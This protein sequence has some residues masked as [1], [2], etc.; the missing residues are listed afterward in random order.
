MNS[1]P[2]NI[3]LIGLGLIGSSLARVIKK[4]HLAKALF[5]YAKSPEHAS[6]ALEIGIIDKIATSSAQIAATCDIVIICTPLTTYDGIFQEIAPAI[7]GRDCIISDVGSLKL[8]AISMANKYFSQ[9]NL[10]NFVP[11]HPIAGTEKTGVEAGFAEL[12][13]HKKLILTPTEETSQ[14]ALAIVS[15]FWCDCGSEVIKLAAREHD[16]IYAEVSHLP[17]FLAYCY[18]F[19]LAEN[20]KLAGHGKDFYLNT[21]NANQKFVQFSRICTSD[22]IIWYGIFAMNMDYLAASLDNFN[23]ELIENINKVKAGLLYID[24]DINGNILHALIEELP[25]IISDTLIKCSPNAPIYAGSGFR[26]LTSFHGDIFSK[27]EVLDSLAEE[28][29]S[30]A[31]ALLQMIKAGEYNKSMAFMQKAAEWNKN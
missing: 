28:I 2:K 30:K 5:G 8:P 24:K 10:Q 26:D 14:D 15:K 11:A 9:E 20:I 22:P 1:E 23:A 19:L 7:K 6:K 12:F 4:N 27:S 25:V 3:G 29:S 16:K 18:A 31:A 17:Q 21:I 13:L